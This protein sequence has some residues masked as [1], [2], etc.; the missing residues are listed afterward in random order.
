MHEEPAGR[1]IG[2]VVNVHSPPGP[3]LLKN[4][5]SRQ[6]QKL[7][8]IHLA[9]LLSYLKLKGRQ[10]GLLINFNVVHLRSGIRRAVNG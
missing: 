1:I 10:V 2:S 6:G 7:L 5:L 8:P 9:Q 3:G 4:E